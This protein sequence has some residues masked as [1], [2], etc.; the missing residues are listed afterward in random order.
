V[1]RVEWSRDGDRLLVATPRQ[2]QLARCTGS[3]VAIERELATAG[4]IE[5][6]ERTVASGRFL[7]A[8]LL[9]DGR[10]VALDASGAGIRFTIHGELYEE[11][12]RGYGQYTAGVLSDDGED[13]AALDR[14]TLVIGATD[15]RRSRR[16]TIGL[17]YEFDLRAETG[18]FSLAIS[19]DGRMI[20]LG[21]ETPKRARK[22]RAT[23]AG[24]GVLV[25]DA[26]PKPRAPGA[27]R[28][29][30]P[31][32][33]DRIWY[34]TE[35]AAGPMLLAFDRQPATRRRLVIAT[36]ERDD[37][38]GTIRVGG[39]ERYPRAHGGGATATALD[40]RGIL[41]AFAYPDGTRER[42]LR[43]DYLSSKAKGEPVVEIADTLWIDPDLT[44]VH[45]LAFDPDGR[46]IAC[47][48]DG[49]VVEIVPVP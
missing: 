9:A 40:D 14:D 5:P 8:R 45:A 33:I 26:T 42:R 34:E 4:E 36:P 22:G 1:P 49:G 29:P 23:L 44:T 25:L 18:R 21:Y 43:I 17:R 48:G 16:H 28:D 35:R 46:R 20:A 12:P 2:L 3:S 7:D 37:S 10:V 13:Y 31:A 38:I 24:R 47:L 39:G 30:L 6:G 15:A 32:V 41:A 19:H 27:W 11:L